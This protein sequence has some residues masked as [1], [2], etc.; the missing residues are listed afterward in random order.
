MVKF[1]LPIPFNGI[2]DMVDGKRAV[3]VLQDRDYVNTDRLVGISLRKFTGQR[4]QFTL[5]KKMHHFLWGAFLGRGL[6]FYLG[7]HECRAVLG[8]NIDF[9]CF[10]LE[11]SR[12]NLRSEEHTSE[13]QSHVNLVSRLLLVIKTSH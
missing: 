1:S 5:F 8:E 3:G 9:A 6:R 11:V 13:L 4:A 2:F 10:K 12:S 7:N